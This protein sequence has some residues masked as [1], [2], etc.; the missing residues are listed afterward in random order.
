MA[1]RDRN[2]VLADSRLAARCSTHGPLRTVLAVARSS[3]YCMGMSLRHH[4][5]HGLAALAALT[6]VTAPAAATELRAQAL[7]VS[8]IVVHDATETLRDFCRTEDGKLYLVLPGGSRWELVT[9]TSDPVI[10]NPGDGSFHVYDRAEVASALAQVEYPL[11]TVSA[12]V[13][14]LPF[15]RRE[16]LE[17][18]AGPGLILLS[19]GVRAL[20]R[21]HQHSE[22]VHELGHVVQYAI[23]PDHDAAAWGTY[24]KLRG[25]DASAHSAGSTHANRPHE[26]WAED[27]RALFGGATANSAGTIENADIAYPTQVAGLD[28]FMQEVAIEAI[29]AVSDRIMTGSV[30]HGALSFTRMGGRAAVLDV[31]DATGRR[32]ASLEPHVGEAGVAW[33]WDGNDRAGHPVQGA[34]LFARARDGQGGTARVV[35]VR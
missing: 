13:F 24:M 25:L 1:R 29:A 7:T 14:I 34:V 32:I 27:F 26:I 11:R 31:Y 4:T 8:G 23:M 17:S 19:P 18:A 16:S 20:S 35:M 5:R 30:A 9:S 15:P 21:E 12:E 22:F 28:Q 3:P 2:N 33:N 10:S 6:L